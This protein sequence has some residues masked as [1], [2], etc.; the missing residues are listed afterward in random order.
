MN[1]TLLGAAGMGVLSGLYWWEAKGL[2]TGTPMTPGIGYVPNL[3]GEIA[4]G[5]CLLLAVLTYW[6][7]RGQ[8]DAQSDCPGERS[9]PGPWIISAALLIYPTF[10]VN[11][12]FIL[13]TLP[14]AYMSMWVMGYKRKFR[15]LAISFVMVFVLNYVFS[16]WLGV[17]FPQGWLS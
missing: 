15:A 11:F 1:K 17:Q 7:S 6:G 12:G 14:L 9:G 4:V 10:L 3:L 16:E 8:S 13:G 5:L 2:P